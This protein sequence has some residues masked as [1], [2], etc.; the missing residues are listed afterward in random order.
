MKLALKLDKQSTVPLS[1][2]LY[3]GLRRMILSGEIRAGDRMPSTR[4]LSEI[5]SVSRPTVTA[6]LDQLALEGYLFT[7][8]G[9]GSYVAPL[10]TEGDRDSSTPAIGS[11]SLPLSLFGRS[12]GSET[13]ATVQPDE[14]EISFYCWR[15]ALDQFPNLEWARILSRNARKADLR[16]LDACTD[17]QGLPELRQALSR[18][19]ARYRDVVSEPD[20]VILVNG[21]N[22]G[23][24]LVGR[25]HVEQGLRA[26]VE[27][28]GYPGAALIL[29]SRG[30]HVVPVKVDEKGLAVDALADKRSVGNAIVYVTPA[31]HFPTGTVMP[32]SRK[33][34]LLDWAH[35][36]RSLVL[37]D[38]YD[39]EYQVQAKP[40]PA[41][42]SLDRQGNVVYLGSLNQLMFPALG[43]AYLIVPRN[44]ISIYKKARPL[45]GDHL[46]VQ[47]QMAVAEFIDRGHLDRH[48]RRLRT[49]YSLR[50]DVLV[51]ELTT[52]FGERIKIGNATS[53]VFVL[54]QFFVAHSEEE[55]EI[56]ARRVGVGITSARPFYQGDCPANQY[57]LGFGSLSEERIREGVRRLASV[58][59]VEP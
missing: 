53:G 28:P 21:L 5:L 49:L 50:R 13:N 52:H 23:I 11:L 35:R 45:I 24:D 26:Y 48:V 2:Q 17:P 58:L 29:K 7:R 6:C 37:E 15:P 36:S 32:L 18:L 31:H 20:Q 59:Q 41:L 27:E 19:V 8:P 3:D 57:V 46:P 16:L 44:L 47:L 39:S 10:H 30:A 14:P 4:A 34:D 22:Q 56:R 54:V 38:D 51:E 33:L 42:S 9:S 1:R 43:L 25:I 12:M 55:I 40:I